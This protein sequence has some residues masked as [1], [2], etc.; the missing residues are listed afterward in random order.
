M[1]QNLIPLPDDLSQFYWRLQSK[2][3]FM[4]G[5]PGNLNNNFGEM[6]KFFEYIINNVGDPF[7]CE[8]SYKM[9]SKSYEKEV[10][11]FFRKIYYLD[12]KSWGYV[13]NGGTESNAMGLLLARSK[14]PDGIIYSTNAHYSIRKNSSILKMDYREI[15]CSN[16]GEISYDDLKTKLLENENSPIMN[17]TIGTT[18]EGAIDNIDK[19]MELMEQTNHKE[20]YI[21]C[22]A[23]LFGGLIPFLSTNHA[24]NFSIKKIDSISVSAHKFFGIPFPSGIFLS[25]ERPNGSFVDSIEYIDSDDTTI[26]GSRNGQSALFLWSLIQH[27]GI[28]GFKQEAMD[29]I[30]N[31]KYLNE[32]LEEIGLDPHLGKNSNIVTFKSP[33]ESIINKWQLARKNGRAHV[34]VMQHVKKPTIDLLISDMKSN[35]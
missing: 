3:P 22:D 14:Y 7:C 32:K 12:E 18:F 20:F 26:S 21:H 13:T 2:A 31:A 4:L 23:A 15:K 17:L 9:H 11:D 16:N 35:L 30:D 1:T 8:E 28:D 34:V 5:Y 19:V 29:C 6:Y 24:L 33:S 10:L 25:K 27:K